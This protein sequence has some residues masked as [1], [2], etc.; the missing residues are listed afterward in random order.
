MWE[1]AQQRTHAAYRFRPGLTKLDIP[2]PTNCSLQTWV[3]MTRTW[4][5]NLD[6]GEVVRV[7]LSEWVNAIKSN[8]YKILMMLRM[9]LYTMQIIL[10]ISHKMDVSQQKRYLVYLRFGLQRII[11]REPELCGQVQQECLKKKRISLTILINLSLQHG[12]GILSTFH[13]Q[14][15][16]IIT[17]HPIHRFILSL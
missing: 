4:H 6:L 16:I 3:W 9:Y 10:R 7:E 14:I 17:L 12:I 5:Y 15:I 1:T 13:I 11:R 8:Q 2:F